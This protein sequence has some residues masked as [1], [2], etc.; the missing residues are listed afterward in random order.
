[1]IVPRELRGGGVISISSNPQTDK[2]RLSVP[3]GS[4]GMPLSRDSL[5]ALLATG[6]SIIPQYAQFSFPGV[7]GGF[8]FG[9]ARCWSC[10]SFHRVVP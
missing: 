9:F 7:A 2:L 6:S 10:M 3:A 8:L 4:L 1:L 5:L